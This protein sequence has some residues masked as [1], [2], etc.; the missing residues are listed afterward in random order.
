M[1]KK[2]PDS[3]VK[4]G[5]PHGTI[6]GPILFLIIIQSL[7]DL[8]LNAILASFTDNTKVLKIIKNLKDIEDLQAE[9]DKLYK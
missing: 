4:S 9:Q 7:D 6:L 1:A 5:V 3:Y 2:D 8:Q